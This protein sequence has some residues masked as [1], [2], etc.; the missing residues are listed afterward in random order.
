MAQ[1]PFIIERESQ[2]VQTFTEDL[3]NGITLDMVLIPPGEF[4]MGSPDDELERQP[5]ESPQHLVTIQQPFFMG[6]FQVTQAQWEQV[7][8]MKQVKRKLN[9][10]SSHFKGRNLPVEQVSW[11]DAEEFC[12]R[13]AAH[14]KR[15][16]RLP[17][18]AE[19]E[20]AC[21]AGTTTPFHFGE[22]LSTQLAN[23]NGNIYG[24]GRKEKS[25]GNTIPVGSL[26]VAN[27]FGLYDMH[28]NVW[29]WCLDRWHDSY[30]GAPTDG[31]AWINP[32]GKENDVRVL[33]GGSWV[34]VPGRCRS[35]Y[36]R[37]DSAGV[38]DLSL[39]FRI[40]YSRARIL[41]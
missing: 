28:G 33:R 5:S 17:S 19:W 38:R 39:G 37:R 4:L 8:K 2:V 7:A 21:R 25:A 20:Y 16:Y 32:K 35:A 12:L 40:V 13:L 31:T 36:R 18:E 23:Y 1:A 30:K 41:L 15:N 29:E 10:K 26:N 14:T 9:P 24:R 34:Y 6:Q 27:A 3:G 11:L 22:T